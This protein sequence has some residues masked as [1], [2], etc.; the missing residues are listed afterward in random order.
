MLNEW[1]KN[2]VT[3]FLKDCLSKPSY[4]AE[5]YTECL[6]TE[7]TEF[8]MDSTGIHKVKQ[9]ANSL[10]KIPDFEIINP[11]SE[12]SAMSNLFEAKGGTVQK[13]DIM[14]FFV[15]P[16]C[17][18]YYESFPS[19]QNRISFLYMEA[20]KLNANG[21]SKEAMKLSQQALRL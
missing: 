1:E 9:L 2:E 3:T 14:V 21:N 16:A 15:G 20:K 7:A 19:M 13:A 10:G 12:G 6:L 17:P 18:W 4:T 8:S 5:Q 11:N